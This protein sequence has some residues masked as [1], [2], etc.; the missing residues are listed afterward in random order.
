MPRREGAGGG[1][2][3]GKAAG[4]GAVGWRLAFGSVAPH[5]PSGH[6]RLRLRGGS[7]T[8]SVRLG[9][10]AD[11]SFL[12]PLRE[13]VSAKLTDEGLKGLSGSRSAKPPPPPP[14]RLPP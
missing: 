13:K 9:S 4:G 14:S 7:R 6:P 5:L 2:A 1:V 12:L 3:R 10:K 11:A 8:Q